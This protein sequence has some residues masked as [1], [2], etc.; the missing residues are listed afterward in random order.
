MKYYSL[1][2]L[3][4]MLIFV[5]CNERELEQQQQAQYEAQLQQ[6][7]I[8]TDQQFR[9]SLN[10]VLEVYFELK[11]SLVSS[12]ANASAE[13]TSDLIQT[14]ENVDVSGL[15]DETT[16][17]WA[18]FADLIITNSHRLQDQSDVDD[19]RYYFEDIS[20]AMIQVVDSFRPAGYEIFVQSCP[21]VRSG[22]A[23]WLSREEQIRNPYHGD[24]MMN[25]GEVI[26]RI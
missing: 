17:I 6:Q 7:L 13:I 11:D 9:N 24:R 14:T 18:S 12:N 20:E 3:P 2:F 1:I 4:I 25:C 10:D 19:Q 16:M 22:T 23:E 15:N 21:M 5:A 26:R 8:E